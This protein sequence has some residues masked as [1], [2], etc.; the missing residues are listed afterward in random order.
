MALFPKIQSPCPYKA[1][2]A[3][4]M[5]GDQCRMCKRQ[6]HDITDWTDQQRITF[7]AECKDEVCVSY[8]LP[9]VAAAAAVALT[10][11]AAPLAAAA[12]DCPDTYIDGTE[13]GGI[14]DLGKV[15]MIESAADKALPELP[16]V[17]E[18]QAP[19]QS[20]AA[21]PVPADQPAPQPAKG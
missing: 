20:D 2:L 19:A 17:Y 18:D 12:Q 7:L 21:K 13:V 16:V 1:N 5:D 15:E 4:V 14:R 9:R 8:R 3:A 6:V 11:L 10:A